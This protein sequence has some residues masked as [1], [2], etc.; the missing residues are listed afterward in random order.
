[1]GHIKRGDLDLAKIAVPSGELL[2]LAG[3]VIA[4]LYTLSAKKREE[5]IILQNTRDHLLPRLI[6][7]KISLDKAEKKASKKL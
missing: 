3:E 1:M 4:P 7:G 2:D 6:S 5:V